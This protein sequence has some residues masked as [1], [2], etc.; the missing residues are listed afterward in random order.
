M[1]IF[2]SI[3]KNVVSNSF[4]QLIII[5]ICFNGILAQNIAVVPFKSFL[6]KDDD[7]IKESKALISSWIY[8]KIYLDVETLSGQ[9][10]SMLL[11]N[12]EPKI[13][14][15]NITAYLK[16][17]DIYNS[18]YI[19]NISHICSFNYHN[20]NSYH[21]L[22][23][24]NYSFYSIS[25]VC[26]ASEKMIF[27]K[28]VDLSE[29]SVID[30]NF[31]HSSNSSN[32]C[33]LAGLVLT[34]LFDNKKI[35]LFYQLKQIINSKNYD[36][37]LYFT[38]P[39][40]GKF[41]FGDIKNNEKIKFNNKNNFISIQVNTLYG[42]RIYWKIKIDK[43]IIGNDYIKETNTFFEIDI[44]IRYISVPKLIFDD[45][46]HLYYLDIGKDNLICFE[47]I[48]NFFFHTVYCDRN[49]F[50]KLCGGYNN[51]PILN[52]NFISINERY[53]ISFNAKDLFLEIGDKIYFFIGYN[54]RMTLDDKFVIGSL[55]LEKY[56]TI[57]NNE[58][59]TLT[60][61]KKKDENVKNSGDI[62][63]ANE[64]NENENN[65][66]IIISLLIFVLSAV[67]F[68]IIGKLFGKKIFVTK[69]KKANELIDEDYDYTPGRINKENKVF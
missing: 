12:E 69:K 28:D 14:T 57:F 60:I 35:N 47:E 51:L 13:H 24:F 11:N 16:S 55:L 17:D 3:Y 1:K 27:Y 49:E 48:S 15:N 7:Y 18:K 56:I 42:L 19:K 62:D 30:L 23:K 36:W 31:I 45:I 46:K 58:E 25:N 64:N 40:E 43:I 44:H 8:R 66:I 54:S 2:N 32:N 59:K 65:K 22:S 6:P 37:G 52:L 67:I 53:N 5:N 68:I 20:S 39:N 21:L 61:F 10:I 50:L 63:I 4:F 41:I 26:Y 9:K 38:S 33:F 29:K 34:N